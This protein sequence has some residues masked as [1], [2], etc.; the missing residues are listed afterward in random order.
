MP[1]R[2]VT[3]SEGVD[4]A[5]R[6]FQARLMRMTNEDVTYT[7]AANLVLLLGLLSH[8]SGGRRRAIWKDDNPPLELAEMLVLLAGMEK[9]D[10][11]GVL[12]ML[13]KEA[14]SAA[15]EQKDVQK[16]T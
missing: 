1:R 9:L 2:T 7:H 12:D 11:E 13:P 3:I 6:S 5:V 15:T 14:R 8:V 16:P 4:A 10:R